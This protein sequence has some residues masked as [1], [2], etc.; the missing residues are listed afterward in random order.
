M[1]TALGLLVVVEKGSLKNGHG[2]L[3][4][5]RD[6][7]EALGDLSQVYR[8]PEYLKRDKRWELRSLVGVE[9][10]RYLLR[11]NGTTKLVDFFE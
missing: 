7:S 5:V 8:K 9:K 1:T 3:L 2:A 6:R 11:H 10:R 4:F